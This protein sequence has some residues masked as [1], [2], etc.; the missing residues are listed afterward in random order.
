MPMRELEGFEYLACGGR[1]RE[2]GPKEAHSFWIAIAHI[3]V[4]TRR[5]Q[6]VGMHLL[7]LVCMYARAH[8][9]T[10]TH[11]YIQI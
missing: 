4:C 2:L 10:R 5:Y 1:G 6:Q 11:M 9:H 8:T 3:V 7:L